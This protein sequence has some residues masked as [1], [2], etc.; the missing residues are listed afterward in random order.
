MPRKTLDITP[1]LDALKARIEKRRTEHKLELGEIVLDSGIHKVFDSG[2]LKEAL[3]SLR[4]EAESAYH[5]EGKAAATTAPFPAETI[6]PNGH[7]VT[8]SAGRRAP[9]LLGE[10]AA[11]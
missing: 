4:D 2:Q 9:D 11:E 3:I 5:K 7:A 8:E 6:K 10:A 1:E